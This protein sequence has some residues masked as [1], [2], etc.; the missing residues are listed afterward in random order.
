MVFHPTYSYYIASYEG[1]NRTSLAKDTDSFFYTQSDVMTN[2]TLDTA[3]M[4]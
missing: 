3:N 4:L 2:H 1:K